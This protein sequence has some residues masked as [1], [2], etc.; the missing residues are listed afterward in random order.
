[1]VN[2]V[3]RENLTKASS[4]NSSYSRNYPKTYS[5]RFIKLLAL[6]VA[7]SL[8]ITSTAFAQATIDGGALEIVDG[9]NVLSTQT[10]PWNV[11]GYLFIGEIG[12]GELQIIEAG[13]VSSTISSI[14][15]FGGSIGEVTVKDTDSNWTTTGDLIVGLSG[16]GTL[17]IEA[18]GSVSN[19]RGFM[20]SSFGST[21]TATVTGAGSSWTNSGE[22]YVGRFGTGTLTV[23]AGGAVSNTIG[24][25]GREA[26]ST[27][28]ATVTG[29]GSSWENLAHLNIGFGGAG[30][31]TI[32]DGGAVSNTDGYIGVENNGTGTATV[33]GGGSS[34]TNSGFLAVGQLGTGTLIISDGGAVSNTVGYIGNYLG[35]TGTATVTGAGSTWTNSGDLTVGRAG[36][37]TLNVEA[38]GAVSNTHGYIGYATDSTG[39]ATVTGAGSSWTNS[40]I[41]YAGFSGN[42]TLNIEDGGTVS[43]TIGL[44]GYNSGSTS[45]ATVTGTDSSWTNA[46]SLVVGDWGI[47]TLNVEAGGSVSNTV[48]FIGKYV[49]GVGTATVTGESSSWTSSDYLYVGLDGTGGLTIADGGSVQSGAAGDAVVY[50]AHN[51]G[52]TGTI[53]IGAAAGDTAVGAGTLA[54]SSVAFGDG[55]GKLVFNHTDTEYNFAPVITGNGAVDV[56][57]GT[58]ILDTQNTYTG[59]TTVSG[60]ALLANGSITSDTYV[61]GT[62]TLGGSGLVGNVFVESGGTLAPGNSIGIIF[63]G[64]VDFAGG[65]SLDVEID[66]AGNSDLLDA[67]GDVTI[68]AGAT[69]NVTPETLGEDGSTYEW[70]TNY[71]LITANTV[72]GVYDTVT[73]TFDLLEAFVSYDAANVYLAMIRNDIDFTTVATTANQISTGDA[74]SALGASPIYTAVAVSGPDNAPLALDLLSGEIHP[75]T[76]SLLIESSQSTLNVIP[77]HN[78]GSGTNVWAQALGGL[79]SVNGDGNA[80]AASQTE[81]GV[82]AGA[83]MDVSRNIDLGLMVG[84]TGATIEVGERNSSAT[85]NALHVGGYGR[86]SAGA[87]DLRFGGLYSTYDVNSSRS[88]QIVDLDETLTAGY[89]ASAMSAFGE[90]SYKLDMQGIAIEPFLNASYTS[91]ETEAFSEEGGAAALSVDASTR[92]MAYATLGVRAN[93]SIMVSDIAANLSGSLGWQ[94]GYGDV[95]APANV[96]FD[97]QPTFGIAGLSAVE[98]AFLVT[99]GLDAAFGDNFN[100]ALEYSGKIAS[101]AQNHTIQLSLTKEF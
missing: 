23:E 9:T 8:T 99:A 68:Q 89:A 70:V 17:N 18:G 83:D 5:L 82:F 16:N 4:A 77:D 81:I 96:A 34:W 41:L 33:T 80:A 56:L 22:L 79:S 47:G 66:A 69:L 38:G 58:T 54:A 1:M 73:D 24:Y 91:L 48:G 14:G 85:S 31:L 62:G 67:S 37:G 71:L 7:T 36:T 101:E 50:V 74:V 20:G 46:N 98:D 44:I 52:S 64:N 59:S 84:F 61:N 3:D 57:S 15:R 92:A 65:S 75:T 78:Y 6:C 42:G 90:V 100:A 88:V 43:N 95:D 27:G 25:I 72:T 94:H 32:S 53:N 26:D 60:G 87:F 63:A 29:A 86:A 30:T 28:T 2:E 35:S 76:G 51:S 97:G 40:G 45:T 12:T 10:S 19:I 49:D 55:T 39:T 11:G 21:G 13:A 93:R